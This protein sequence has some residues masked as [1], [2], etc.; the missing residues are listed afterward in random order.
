MRVYKRDGGKSYYGEY[1]ELDGTRRQ[2]STRCRDARAAETVCRQWE[3]DAADPHHA[4]TRAATLTDALELLLADRRGKAAAGKKAAATVSFYEQKAGVLTRLL[5]SDAQ[6]GYAPLRLA[7]LTAGHADGYVA[8]RRLEWSAP[9]RKA[10]LG[11]SGA[12]LRP[13]REGRHVTENTIS[14]ELVTLRAALKLARRAAIWDGDPA[15]ILPVGFAPEYQPKTRVLTRAELDQ[16]IGT[17]TEDHAARCAFMVATSAEWGATERAQREDVALDLSAALLRGTK[18][19][20]RHRTVPI[21]TPDQ[22]SLLRYALDHATGKNGMLFEPWQNRL[23]DLKAACERIGIP[24]CSP[25]DLRR[26]FSNWL[27]AEGVPP[28]LIGMMMGHKDSRMV[29]LVYGRLQGTQLAELLGRFVDCHANG[30]DSAESAAFPATAATLAARN[31][32]E[33]APRPGLEPG[34]HGLT[35]RCSAS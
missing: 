3:R 35:V 1:Y 14:K 28:H 12:V 13:Q 27:R 5:E 21:V 23:R 24:C 34:T 6:G 15:Q 16:L 31:P 29:E 26:T 22:K 19:K 7:D 9:P 33:L 18:R 8:R 32:L 4:R 20:T 11:V 30:T 25:N 10:V 2:R 17:L